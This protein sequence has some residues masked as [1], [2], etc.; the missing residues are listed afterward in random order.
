M[1][2]YFMPVIR[3][4]L[5]TRSRELLKQGDVRAAIIATATNL[6]E[7]LFTKLYFEKGIE[8]ELMERWTLGTYVTWNI[9]LKL[10]DQKWETLLQKFN[11]LRN[12]VAHERFF[13]ERCLKDSKK[14]E[15]IKHLVASVCDFVDQAVIRYVSSQE[16]E[17]KYWEQM[18]RFQKKEQKFFEELE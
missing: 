9:S 8:P 18:K 3:S 15:R 6:E 4:I 13:L 5:T 17:A 7:L 11:R 16:T 10:V 1:E 12:F 14:S 2:E